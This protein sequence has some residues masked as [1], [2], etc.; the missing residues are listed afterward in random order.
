MIWIEIILIAMGL[1]VDSL[2]ASAAGGAVM[3]QQYKR[4]ITKMPL[5]FALCQGV[6]TVFGYFVGKGMNGLIQSFDHWVA[7]ALL[8]F[9]GSRMIYCRLKGGEENEKAGFDPS[10]MRVLLGLGIATSIDAAAIGI[11]LAI[12]NTPIAQ[13]ALIIM[14]T[15]FLFSLAGVVV[16]GKLGSKFDSKVLEIIGGIVLIAIGAKILIDHLT[17]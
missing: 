12:M 1:S 4:I 13:T 2:V 17:A 5:V 8:F 15:T 10:S 16:G 6:M 9:L 14:L 11:S 7:F 3:Q